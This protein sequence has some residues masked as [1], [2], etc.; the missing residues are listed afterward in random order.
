MKKVSYIFI[1]LL[2]LIQF[3]TYKAHA[4]DN[5]QM[6]VVVKVDEISIDFDVSPEI[7]NNRV[8]VPFRAIA[9]ALSAN[10]NWEQDTKTITANKGNINVELTINSSKMFYNNTSIKLDSPPIIKNDRTLIPL[11]FFSE[12]FNC[13]VK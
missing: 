9:D 8:M 1:S 11:R 6:N 13:D 3:T 7:I 10:V 2:L 12:A 4:L 5:N